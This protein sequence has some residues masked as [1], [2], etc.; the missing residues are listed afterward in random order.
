MLT[1]ECLEN[2]VNGKKVYVGY[3][4]YKNLVK[5]SFLKPLTVNRMTD[6]G[7]IKK[8]MEYI[9]RRE[10]NYPPIVVSVEEGCRHIFDSNSKEL[11][12][13]KNSKKGYEN[14][15]LVIID[16]QHRY[17]SIKSLLKSN[18][19]NI[20]ILDRKQAIYILTDM[21]ESEQ[22]QC[23]MDINDNMKR[24]SSVSKR[25]FE[26]SIANYISLKVIKQLNIIDKVN[27]KNDQ[28][29]KKY[30]YKFIQEANK[31]LFR[32]FKLSNYTEKNLITELDI[33]SE[34]VSVL[35][36]YI[37]TFIDDNTRLDI[38]F[39]KLEDSD[40][41]DYKSIKT[42]I[43]IKAFIEILVNKSSEL[44]NFKDIP[45]EKL[46]DIIKKFIED[47]ISEKKIN[48]F[49]HE[50]EINRLDKNFKYSKIKE[51][52]SGGKSNE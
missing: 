21:T 19:N 44:L 10:S 20:E 26:I 41:R 46:E 11:I 5:N 6:E 51:I 40:K 17:L 15:R 34:K 18:S 43:F 4:T 9:E 1:I 45:I 13:E 28:C 3:I 23:F 50:D 35:W 8:M 38:G 16:G 22:R 31:I 33:Y 12:V 25:I 27:I 32:E 24:V 30:P 14:N 42:E 47:L 2:R 52:L 49:S 7:R 48:F 36:R 29:T 39:S 37:L